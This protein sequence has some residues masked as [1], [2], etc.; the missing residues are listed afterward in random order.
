MAAAHAAGSR[1]PLTAAAPPAIGKTVMLL[2]SSTAGA[3]G[4]R[5]PRWAGAAPS[6][7]C[8]E[9]VIFA[10]A[11][12][13]STCGI[14]RRSPVARDCHLA[15]APSPSR[16]KHLPKVERGVQQNIDTLL[17][18]EGGGGGGAKY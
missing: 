6:S 8:R 12:S 5:A 10:G 14:Q 11:L 1:A 15:D 3:A 13:S 4:S 17:K 7:R 2:I 16:L 18:G 9:A